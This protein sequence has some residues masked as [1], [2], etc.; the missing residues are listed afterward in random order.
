MLVWD[1]FGNDWAK[2]LK[3]QL[4]V[5]GLNIRKLIMAL[6]LILIILILMMI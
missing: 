3:E 6:F 2:D 4:K 5:N 1:S